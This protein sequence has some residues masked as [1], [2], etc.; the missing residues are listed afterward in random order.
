MLIIY[1][2]WNAYPPRLR[3][4][5]FQIDYPD[6]PEFAEPEARLPFTTDH[7]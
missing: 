6:K 5:G 4:K 2:I 3:S 1:W 7:S